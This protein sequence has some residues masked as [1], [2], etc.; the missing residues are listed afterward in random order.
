MHKRSRNKDQ[1]CLSETPKSLSDKGFVKSLT[2]VAAPIF[3]AQAH[4]VLQAQR[5]GTGGKTTPAEHA[6]MAIAYVMNTALGWHPT[7]IGEAMDRTR[8]AARHACMTV[9]DLRDNPD[10]DRRV[11]VLEAAAVVIAADYLT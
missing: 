7:R 5:G 10:F 8:Y 11:A 1:I 2:E 9:E 4:D 6:R 3:G